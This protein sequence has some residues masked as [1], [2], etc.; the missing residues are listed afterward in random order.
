M[1][2]TRI[3]G[4][5]APSLLWWSRSAPPEELRQ[6]ELR[7]GLYSRAVDYL[8]VVQELGLEVKAVHEQAIVTVANPEQLNELSRHPDIVTIV[9]PR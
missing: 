6:V 2:P 4:K 8:Y 1:M 7:F 3:H 9:E 5:M